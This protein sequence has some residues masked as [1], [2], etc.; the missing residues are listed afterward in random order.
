MWVK[1]EKILS[2]FAI[3][4][5]RDYDVKYSISGIVGLGLIFGFLTHF[6]G[7]LPF[8]QG[9]WF[10]PLA[11]ATFFI[12]PPILYGL[13]LDV[14]ST[15]SK[16]ERTFFISLENM[17]IVFIGLVL[18]VFSEV[19][20]LFLVGVM[21]TYNVVGF[22]GVNMTFGASP[23][24]F[25]LFYF[26]SVLAVLHFTGGFVMEFSQM[27]AFLGVGAGAVLVVFINEKVLNAALP[28]SSVKLFSKFVNEERMDLDVGIKTD[29][30]LQRLFMKNGG[31]KIFYIPWVHPGPLKTVGGGP[32]SGDIIDGVNERFG[33]DVEGFFW[34]V[35]SY[36][37]M[38]PCNS[39]FGERVL[40]E[41]VD[42][43]PEYF[44]KGTKMFENDHDVVKL[45]GQRFG[46]VY[47]LIYSI[48]GADDY[49]IEIFKQIREMTGEKVICI[50]T[51]Q[52]QPAKQGD[53][54][55]KEEKIAD[56]IR[57]EGV[58][59]VDR[60]RE[61]EEFELKAGFALSEDRK[62]MALVEEVGGDKFLILG[63][64]RNGLPDSLRED[65]SEF[66]DLFDN[67]VALT[68]DSHQTLEFLDT[69]VVESPDFEL[70]EEAEENLEKVQVG[71]DERTLEEV[72][73]MGDD[74]YKFFS[75]IG[76]TM[77]YLP[78]LLGM[79]HLIYLFALI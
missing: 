35:P 3:F 52:L 38:D 40:E 73:V 60:L 51:H 28:I 21:F 49:D 71:L 9:H 7:L 43:E 62:K 5:P 32:I 16:R 25:P 77:I 33:E 48:K 23:I 20:F 63:M 12:V 65:L 44:E 39:D 17:C 76:Y 59:M 69:D 1:L 61:A 75:S 58:E 47:L 30:L 18:G 4:Y 55:S 42:E 72:Q 41:P 79:L 11:D 50:D 37:D 36:H 24:I 68:T 6:F 78:I 19:L 67:S 45:H 46:D 29:A 70:V 64:D 53:I 57:E 2:G 26:G 54:I 31:K 15:S 56:K 22:V 13:L 10:S 8:F 66:D 27:L 14:I 34:H 74:F